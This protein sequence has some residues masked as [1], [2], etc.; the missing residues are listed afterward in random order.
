MHTL[1]QRALA[2]VGAVERV[3]MAIAMVMML[4]VMF[5]VTAD[6]FMRY[7]F[8]SPF[9]WAYDLISLYLMAGIFFL[10]LSQ[11]YA[12]GAHVSVDVLQQMFPPRLKRLTECV[13]TGT[14]FVVFALMADF[15]LD[16]TIDAYVSADVVAG[17]IAWPTWPSIALMPLGTGL[18]CIRLALFFIGHMAS[19]VTGRD[20][21]PINAG[22]HQGGEVF[23]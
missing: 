6:V 15:G 17:A 22:G 2:A 13:V 23:E 11:A 4:A 5:I 19:L 7:A 14:A 16:R 1:I 21:I 8:N 10:A 3:L 20:I 18:L 12:D 9:S